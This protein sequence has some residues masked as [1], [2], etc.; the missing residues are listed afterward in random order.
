MSW[1][2]VWVCGEAKRPA[3]GADGPQAPWVKAGVVTREERALIEATQKLRTTRDRHPRAVEFHLQLHTRDVALDRA[4]AAPHALTFAPD[5]LWLAV[6]V[7]PEGSADAPRYVYFA[8]RV[9]PTS[10]KRAA[11]KPP[12]GARRPIATVHLR[13]RAKSGV[14]PLEWAYRAPSAG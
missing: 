14:S 2:D 11:P 1:G 12:A 8:Q 6:D 3:I 5:G 10:D 7:T 4:G 13:G 9:H